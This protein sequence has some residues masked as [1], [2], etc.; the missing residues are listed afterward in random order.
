MRN[1][2]GNYTCTLAHS[3]GIVPLTITRTGTVVI[4]VQSEFAGR[5][6]ACTC[7]S[8]TLNRIMVVTHITLIL[9]IFYILFI[10]S[11]KTWMLTYV[12]C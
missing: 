6:A 2:S 10:I 1:E 7:M 4:R 5:L 3:I 12:R 11:F 9:L 8:S